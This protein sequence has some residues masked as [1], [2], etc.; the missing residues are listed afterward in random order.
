MMLPH[1]IM[2]GHP[3]ISMVA[4][5]DHSMWFTS[6]PK[7]FRAD[8]WILY[9]MESPVLAGNRGLNIGRIFTRDGLLVAT[10]VQEALIRL[11]EDGVARPG[12]ASATVGA[13]TVA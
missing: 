12:P 11:R 7:P 6:S 1:G 8:E 4:S 5:L 9:E 13:A 2:Y 10:A 3:R